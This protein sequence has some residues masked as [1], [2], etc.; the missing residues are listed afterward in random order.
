MLGSTQSFKRLI[1]QENPLIIVISCIC[2]KFALAARD[3]CNKSIPSYINTFLQSLV[4]HMN[5][6]KRS[7]AFE[8]FTSSF[9]ETSLKILPYSK[10]RWLGRHTCIKRIHVRK[11]KNLRHVSSS[12]LEKLK[13]FKPD[14]VSWTQCRIAAKEMEMEDFCCKYIQTCA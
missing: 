14:D 2:H 6:T 5:S 9:Q 1:L 8:Q 13:I 11:K 12:I 3:S 4:H 10:T 7:Q